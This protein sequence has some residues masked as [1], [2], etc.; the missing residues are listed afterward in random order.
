MSSLD[1]PTGPNG[2]KITIFGPPLPPGSALPS[3]N[4]WLKAPAPEDLAVLVPK[5]PFTNRVDPT[6]NE[7]S[8]NFQRQ[9]QYFSHLLTSTGLTLQE[10]LERTFEPHEVRLLEPKI[11]PSLMVDSQKEN[12]I[13]Y[14]RVL[15]ARFPSQDQ[16]L[17]LKL[18]LLWF[19][20]PVAPILPGA[21]DVDV[22]MDIDFGYD[23]MEIKLDPLEFL[24][25][26]VERT[27][28]KPNDTGSNVRKPH[29]PFLQG[30]QEFPSMGLR[31][32]A[33]PTSRVWEIEDDE[34]APP[35]QR[36]QIRIFGYQG[37]VLDNPSKSLYPA[38]VEA[39][40][41][42]L[43][44]GRTGKKTNY[45]I[46]MEIWDLTNDADPLRVEKTVGM[47]NHGSGQP[48]GN[49]TI[50]A[51]LLRFFVYNTTGKQYSC[52]V[53]FDKEQPPSASQPY[54]KDDRYLVRVWDAGKQALAYMKVP[55]VLQSTH[56]PN[57]FSSEYLRA[58]RVLFP[59][60]PHGYIQFVEG[61]PI[62][63]GL[64]DPPPEIWD[65]VINEKSQNDVLPLLQFNMLPI[66]DNQVAVWVP[67][68]YAYDNQF[69]PHS[70]TRGKISG[71]IHRDYLK[72]TGTDV[73]RRAIQFILDTVEAGN[74]MATKT[75]NFSGLEIWLPGDR[76]FEPQSI[77]Q[78]VACDHTGISVHGLLD[79]RDALSG[80]WLIR[81]ESD[82]IIKTNMVVRPVYR[83]YSFRAKNSQ[84]RFS[85]STLIDDYSL[86]EFKE[87]VRANLHPTY[88]ATQTNQVLHLS[89][90]TWGVNKTDFVIRSDTDEY[91]WKWIVR[92]LTEPDI[93]VA[94]EYWTNDWSVEDETVW[95][96]RYDKLAFHKIASES[97]APW[98]DRPFSNVTNEIF[99]R[100]TNT[101][102]GANRARELREKL[103]WNTPS[104]FTNPVKPVYSTHA[105]LLESI[106]RT[107]PYV[108]G[109]TT[110]MRTPSEMARLERE[111]HMLRGNLLDRIRECPYNEC[112]RYFPF[113]DSEG[114]ARHITEDHST[115]KCFLCD[116]ESALFPYY[117]Q[118]S[119]RRH[120]IKSHG[121][122][123][124]DALNGG[125]SAGPDNQGPRP[126]GPK[127]VGPEPVSPEPV[128][129][130]PVEP[131]P[132]A[133]T[134]KPKPRIR[135][136]LGTA[137]ISG[138]PNHSGWIMPSEGVDF[139][140]AFFD[141]VQK[142]PAYRR[143]MFP[144]SDSRVDK[145]YNGTN[146][147][148]HLV[149][150][151]QDDPN[152]AGIQTSELPWPPYEGINIPPPETLPDE[153]E[154]PLTPNPDC[155]GAHALQHTA[156]SGAS[157][158]AGMVFDGN[159]PMP[160]TDYDTPTT[161][162]ITSQDDRTPGLTVE[163]AIGSSSTDEPSQPEYRSTFQ[164]PA[165]S[166]SDDSNDDY[167]QQVNYP[168]LPSATTPGIA[169]RF[170][171]AAP[172][173]GSLL[174]SEFPST[175]EEEPELGPRPKRRRT[176][177]QR[178]PTFTQGMFDE[179][180]VSEEFSEAGA[181]PDP[182]GNLDPN[183]P[184]TPRRRPRRSGRKPK[185]RAGVR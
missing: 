185:S 121:K 182:V 155:P 181:V 132:P 95:G 147:L 24:D 148:N 60:I 57:Q 83:E 160:P 7:N 158:L 63:Y 157:A 110:A 153:P 107:G 48:S 27:Y 21:H 18:T 145:V 32:G 96:P 169:S 36:Q 23:N 131:E 2:E 94:L 159:I 15:R 67:G 74:E 104:I 133:I 11:L 52:F 117:D 45:G 47:V 166:S 170:P 62:T 91:G 130:E 66:P 14:N 115:L 179:E 176:T 10:I 53:H 101:F 124:L 80:F 135:R 39:V 102:D 92:R 16:T 89:Q 161:T 113:R 112:Q 68:V 37:T 69:S 140:K 19:G 156:I 120:F 8:P 87:A 54:G 146:N 61:G 180:T 12:I 26:Y 22:E 168:S 93:T 172:N 65:Q 98:L 149:G 78:R 123:I 105:P 49:D 177:A 152:G 142:Y 64:F 134:P 29:F 119:L 175:G 90:T 184:R 35:P 77:P 178:D 3:P 81:N 13:R 70:G 106:I 76:F 141:F 118:N 43:G 17:E 42:L 150:S 114:L 128:S 143:T 162:D 125:G 6:I 151:I 108:P 174:A 41:Q 100:S 126:P 127:P 144:L 40:D 183:A 164:F 97:D 163:E 129:P 25:D 33:E 86:D 99:K 122:D 4:K 137:Q 1:P 165:F 28:G 50:Y 79:W 51:T 56:K 111:T 154:A 38:F 46:C 136:G 82:A 103:F 139:A 72:L 44:R 116:E 34:T 55:E 138:L 9:L 58:M 73:D 20:L 171:G 59:E 88:S 75:P 71:M 167:P 30:T 84:N 85:T 31:G 173:V 5:V 109:Y